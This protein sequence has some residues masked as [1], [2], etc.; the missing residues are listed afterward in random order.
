MTVLINSVV[1]CGLLFFGDIILHSNDDSIHYFDSSSGSL[2]L[3]AKTK[4]DF[5]D[6]LDDNDFANDMFMIPLVNDCRKSHLLLGN[7]QCYSLKRFQ[8]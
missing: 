8:F 5:C 1:L 4:D 2:T 6:K 3:K 7:L